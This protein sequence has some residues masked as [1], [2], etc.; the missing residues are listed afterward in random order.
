M[1]YQA[2]IHQRVIHSHFCLTYKIMPTLEPLLSPVKKLETYQF[3][4][5]FRHNFHD[6]L[7][8]DFLG[9]ASADLFNTAATAAQLAA[10]YPYNIYEGKFLEFLDCL[11]VY[12]YS[13]FQLAVN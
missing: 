3:S 2:A 12:E 13:R 1:K 10:A 9:G 8:W 7:F 4:K 6:I 11:S 5:Y